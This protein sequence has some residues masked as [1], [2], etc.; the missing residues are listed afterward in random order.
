M[1]G[2]S[3]KP[4]LTNSKKKKENEKNFLLIL[5]TLSIFIKPV[6]LSPR[7]HTF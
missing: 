1:M 4:L 6:H 2:N 7:L 3:Y 5:N